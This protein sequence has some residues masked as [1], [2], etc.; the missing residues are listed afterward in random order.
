MSMGGSDVYVVERIV[1]HRTTSHGAEFLVRWEGYG[2]GDDTWECSRN[3]IDKQLI[4]D[5]F[6]DAD[7]AC[8]DKDTGDESG[9]ESGDDEDASSEDAASSS[10]VQSTMSNAE[11]LQQAAAEDLTLVPSCNK[12]GYRFV[13]PSNRHPMKRGSTKFRAAFQKYEHGHDGS[14]VEVYLGTFST[15]MEAALAVAR[16]LG[17]EK[18]AA[19]ATRAMQEAAARDVP[20]MSEAEAES[21]AAAEG[22]HLIRYKQ[23]Q[24][25]FKGVVRRKNGG[26]GRGIATP[27][28]K[29]SFTA[30]VNSLTLANGCLKG[31]KSAAEAALAIAR[32]L[33]PEGCADALATEAKAAKD[34]QAKL[35]AAE[36]R[37]AAAQVKAG[38]EAL[39]D[40]EVKQLA[41]REGLHLEPSNNPTGFAGVTIVS[42]ASSG[43]LQCSFPYRARLGTRTSNCGTAHRAAL[44][45]A[46]WKAEDD[47]KKQLTVV[48]KDLIR[49]VVDAAAAERKRDETA[50]ARKRKREEKERQ[51]ERREEKLAQW[52]QWTQWKRWVEGQLPHFVGAG[53]ATAPPRAQR[54]SLPPPALPP[55]PMAMAVPMTVPMP[56][57]ALPFAMAM[58]MVPLP[59]ASLPA[60]L[61]TRPNQEKELMPII[62]LPLP[63]PQRALAA[64]PQPAQSGSRA[65]HGLAPVGPQARASNVWASAGRSKLLFDAL[66]ASIA[67]RALR[68]REA[69]EKERIRRV[70]AEKAASKAAQQQRADEIAA[71]NRVR[72][73]DRACRCSELDAIEQAAHEGL[74]LTRSES[75]ASG[76]AHVSTGTFPA[77]H[78]WPG[79]RCFVALAP[80]YAAGKDPS[81]QVSTLYLTKRQ[82]G[83][84]LSAAEAALA[85]ARIVKSQEVAIAEA[86]A[87]LAAEA[88]GQLTR[89]R[90]P[91][92]LSRASAEQAK[93]REEARQCEASRRQRR[94]SSLDSKL[95]LVDSCRGMQGRSSSAALP[96]TSASTWTSEASRATPPQMMAEDAA[97]ESSAAQDA[98]AEPPEDNGDPPAA[99]SRY[100]RRLTTLGK[101]PAWK[102]GGLGDVYRVECLLAARRLSGSGGSTRRQ[103]LVRWAEYSADADSWEDEDSILDD[104][105]IRAFD[106]AGRADRKGSAMRPRRRK[107]SSLAAGSSSDLGAAETGL[108]RPADSS[109]PH[110]LQPGNTHTG[111]RKLGRDRQVTILPVA[112]PFS[113]DRRETPEA[114]APTLLPALQISRDLSVETAALL[115]ASAYGPMNAWCFVMPSQHG[116]GLYARTG[117]LPGQAISEYGGPLIPLALLTQG[118]YAMQIPGTHMVID[119]ASENSPFTCP[120]YPAIYANHSCVPNARLEVWPTARPGAFERRQTIVLVADE[121]IPAGHE[122][123]INYES[124]AGAAGQY[125]GECP[126]PETRWRTDWAQ[127]PPPAADDPIYDR[128]LQLQEAAAQGRLAAPCALLHRACEPIPWHGPTGGDA[129]LCAVV[130]MLTS[131][132]SKKPPWEQIAT[133]IPGR[134]ALAC[135]ERWQLLER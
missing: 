3:I 99:L 4:Q 108:H 25:G 67:A 13:A 55:M 103:F 125:W 14:H 7:A 60:T 77:K 18:S 126:P 76:Y 84:Y 19:A 110:L 22:L 96:S 116:C 46:R 85:V 15:P 16:Y 68:Q 124:G 26:W 28:E 89:K 104:S 111:R 117:L 122:I 70:A 35:D 121:R 38:L 59:K 61:Q 24:S 130:P 36:A 78:E 27:L 118:E 5:Y 132:R 129:R 54:P 105:L 88:S 45:Y 58:P 107:E 17:P 115:T 120:T 53:G 91:T 101:V 81:L 37:K 56:L 69:E 64:P 8:D 114:A 65:I 41:E 119:G 42:R 73:F 11:V 43:E 32:H 98:I 95:S 49:Q 74:T 62:P 92:E 34:A 40:N 128:L 30:V 21:L 10:R 97:A 102:V 123:R 48:V 83:S 86:Q 90:V 133:H 57:G 23:S 75:S 71:A 93:Q 94:R 6:A 135:R 2:Q 109:R 39:S 29:P 134:G 80:I 82:L 127:P 112:R 52:T 113:A 31:F 100:P 12:A 44:L 9:D 50:Q 66:S 106:E 1:Q 79:H 51:E 33:G 131:G 20:P 72:R 87:A 63:P 47:E